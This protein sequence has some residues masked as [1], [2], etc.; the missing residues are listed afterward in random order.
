MPQIGLTELLIIAALAVL[1]FGS[2]LPGV[3]KALGSGIRNFKKGL[4]GGHDEGDAPPARGPK[5]AP[6]DNRLSESQTASGV[7]YDSSGAEPQAASASSTTAV[8]ARVQTSN[9]PT[10]L[11]GSTPVT[12]AAAPPR[13]QVVD[14]DSENQG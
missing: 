9:P 3:G 6:S 8:K 5:T 1:L 13:A 14:V 10:P 12:S 7:V 11:A 4:S 2:R